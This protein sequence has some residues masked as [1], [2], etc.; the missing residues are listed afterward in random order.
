MSA[1]MH[2]HRR[3]LIVS[4]S[5]AD[6]CHLRWPLHEL[7]AEPAIEPILV[8]TGALLVPEYGRAVGVI[9]A[10]GFTVDERV[11][12]VLAS[13]TEA[14]AGRTIGLAT[15]GFAD[16]I[17]R[18]RP[19]AVLVMADRFE[20]LAPAAA[21]L[22]AR[23]P[24]VHVEGGEAST[25]VIDHAVRNALT[26]M[27]SV[28]LVTTELA[29][30]RLAAM[31]E[32]SWRIHRV[33]AGSLDHLR[34]TTLPPAAE[35]GARHGVDLDA[36][37]IVVAYHPVTLDEQPAAGIDAVLD[38]I[39]A[40]GPGVRAIFCHPNADAG[41]RAIVAR[42][43][44]FAAGRPGDAVL[45][46]LDP[47]DYWS[48]LRGAS[49]MC[50]NSSSG[51][52]ESAS[53]DLPAVNIGPRQDGRERPANV[54]DVP[55][56]AGAIAGALRRAMGEDSRRAAAAAENPYGDGRA[57]ERMREVLRTLSARD[58]LLHKPPVAVPG[59]AGAGG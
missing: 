5:R 32:E 28:H 16:V 12:C 21:A 14:A 27:A 56:E 58:R 2:E 15:I 38:G 22:A 50:G 3:I 44:D 31:G 19:D 57:G 40:A 7:R 1:A 43:R 36:P 48:L 49:A 53:V 29:A 55:A 59:V 45:V 18:R 30:R 9:E 13:D 11:D 10:D 42:M 47:P 52:M 51:I 24:I 35:V 33:G 17:E 54:I 8:A 41:G 23:V 6:W 39:A 37:Y 26:M 46:N 34:R 25:G 20:M 4:S